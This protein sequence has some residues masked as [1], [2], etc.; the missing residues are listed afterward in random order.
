MP[1]D[2]EG[3]HERGEKEE[4]PLKKALLYHYWLI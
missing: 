1:L 4:H 3:P 2:E